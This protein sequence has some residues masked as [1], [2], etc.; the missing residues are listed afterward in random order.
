MIFMINQYMMNRK[1]GIKF[2]FC[3]ASVIF[4]CIHSAVNPIVNPIQN[5][6]V[7]FIIKE[8]TGEKIEQSSSIRKESRFIGKHLRIKNQC[9]CVGYLFVLVCCRNFLIFTE[10]FGF[11]MNCQVGSSISC[12]YVA[13]LNRYTFIVIIPRKMA[14]ILPKR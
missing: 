9:S 10:R 4:E 8:R 5:A 11:K 2:Q 13:M 14:D 3:K 6:A 7:F 12:S 1:K